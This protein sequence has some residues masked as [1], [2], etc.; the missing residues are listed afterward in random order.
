MANIPLKFVPPAED[1]IV[2]L[3]IYESAQPDQNFIQIERVTTIGT[4]PNYI[5]EYTST[6][7]ASLNDYF[8]IQWEDS[9]GNVSPLSASIKGGT[10]TLIGE[11]VERVKRRDEFKVFDEVVIAQEAEAI[12]NYVYKVDPYS[13]LLDSVPYYKLSAL[14]DLTMVSILSTNLMSHVSSSSTDYTAGMISERQNTSAATTAFNNLALIE[15]RALRRLGI[16]G[17]IIGKLEPSNDQIVITGQKS[18]L[19]MSRLLRVTA[20]ITEEMV[21]QDVA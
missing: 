14:V 10:R 17:S 4:F 15:K 21:E 12:V 5:D 3:R 19:N 6:F 7:G 8:A 20:I 9:D 18:V 1:N 2:A 11:I 13:I 16:G